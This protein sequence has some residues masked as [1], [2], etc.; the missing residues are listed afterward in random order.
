MLARE[1]PSCRSLRTSDEHCVIVRVLRARRAS[2]RSFPSFLIELRANRSDTL[3]PG[4]RVG[5][6]EQEWWLIRENLRVFSHDTTRKWFQQLSEASYFVWNVRGHSA[7]LVVGVQLQPIEV[8]NFH[9]RIF[10]WITPS[11]QIAS[12]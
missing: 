12:F 8:W 4:C 1:R 9:I 5:I 6:V 2:G 11:E 3:S 7:F 10:I